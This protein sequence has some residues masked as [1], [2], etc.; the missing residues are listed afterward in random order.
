ME[1]KSNM[2]QL[3]SQQALDLI[4]K[5]SSDASLRIPGY[6]DQ[7]ATLEQRQEYLGNLIMREPGIFLQQYGATCQTAELECFQPLRASNYEVD[8]YMTRLT[9]QTEKPKAISTLVRN[10]RLAEMIRRLEHTTYFSEV[11]MRRREPYL[12]HLWIGQYD[13][14]DSDHH[15][16]E[17]QQE[18]TAATD[19]NKGE[20]ETNPVA[21]F[22]GN[23][24]DRMDEVDLMV[25]REAESEA[26]KLQEE[27]EEEEESD[28]V[29]KKK[30][31]NNN[32]SQSDV[33][34][35]ISEQQYVENRES[36]LDIMKQ[37]F[38]SGKEQDVDYNKIDVNTALDDLNED[39]IRRDAEDA[40]FDSLT[41]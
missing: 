37:K 11:E 4:K 30:D 26:Y 14:Y 38:L 23:L 17:E 39:E 18:T 5:I 12:H 6:R 40:Y 33:L 19:D 13:N 21:I 32:R 20:G 28:N 36:F 34:P 24:L 29:E 15:P 31:N 35:R 8:F 7:K 25:R 41:D 1:N 3:T 2:Q 10:R 16:N 22:A 9:Q 27:E